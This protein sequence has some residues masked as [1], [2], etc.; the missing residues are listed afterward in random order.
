MFGAAAVCL[1]AIGSV[2]YLWNKQNGLLAKPT[3]AEA[4]A[5]DDHEDLTDLT[6]KQRT[7][8]NCKRKVTAAA[9]AAHARCGNRMQGQSVNRNCAEMNPRSGPVQLSQPTRG[10]Q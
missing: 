1:T 8:G 4:G 9:A 2:H 6:D 5:R 7:C 10:P 3:E